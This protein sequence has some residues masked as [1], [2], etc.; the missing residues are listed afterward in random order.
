METVKIV[1][2]VEQAPKW[3]RL[4]EQDDYFWKTPNEFLRADGIFRAK[5]D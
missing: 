2:D 4:G 1:F 3:G 5:N